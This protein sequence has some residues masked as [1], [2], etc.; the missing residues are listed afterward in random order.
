MKPILISSLS[1][2]MISGLRGVR[3]GRW[4]SGAAGV[5]VGA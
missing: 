3:W 5:G 1:A 4:P 2:L